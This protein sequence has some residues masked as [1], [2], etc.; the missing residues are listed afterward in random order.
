MYFK[1][2]SHVSPRP[3]WSSSNFEMF[4]LIGI[5]KK[6]RGRLPPPPPDPHQGLNHQP[7]S[8]HGGTYGSSHLC[9]RGWPCRTSMEGE[10]LV[11]GKALCP[12]VEECHGGEAG[13]G[14][15]V[16][17]WESTLIETGGERMG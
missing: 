2:Q 5:A 15:W 3:Q 14:G 9:S 6:V 1:P 11:P 17:G 12:S 13:V 7:K 10:I 16:G 4:A 8:T